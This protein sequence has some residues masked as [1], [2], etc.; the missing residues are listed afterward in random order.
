MADI[1]NRYI[2]VGAAGANPLRRKEVDDIPDYQFDFV[3]WLLDTET[4][5]SATASADDV[6]LT[7]GTPTVSTTIV[8]VRISDGISGTSYV[9]TVDAELTDGQHKITKLTIYV[10]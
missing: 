3:N 2:Y 1:D 9:V 7:V 5:T 8:K 6:D 10:I 4:I